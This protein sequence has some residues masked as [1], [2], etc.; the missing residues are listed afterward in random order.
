M[1]NSVSSMHTKK[2]TISAFFSGVGGIELGFEQTGEFRVVYANEF[3]KNAQI[4][5]VENYPNIHLDKRDIHDVLESEVPDSDVI[6]GGFPCQAFSI[7]G[8]RKGFEDERGD[9]F[10]ELLRIIKSKQPEV[11]F[12]ENVKNMVTHDHGNT[13]KI[14]REAL[15]M[16]GYFIKWKVLN[17]KEYGNIPQNR[18]RIYVVGFRNKNSFEKFDFPQ[19]IPLTKTLKDVINF[20]DIQDDKFYYKDGRQPFYDKLADQIT[21]ENTIYQWRRQYVRENKSGVVPTLTANMGTGGHNVPLIKAK[22]GIRKLT[23]RETFNVQGYPKNFK[24]PDISNAQLYKQAGN[25]VVVPVIKRIATNIANALN[26]D[27]EPVRAPLKEGKYYIMHTK[28]DGRFSGESSLVKV[29][30]TIEELESFA[31]ERKI[32]FMSNKEYLKN[33]QKNKMLDFYSFE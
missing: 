27:S 33:V 10:F 15:N 24:L 4:T 22:S 2:F 23:P 16:N 11:I 29:V 14:I 9:L 1:T 8:Y 30:S 21:D 12:I 13:F 18:E 25:S 3:D 6:V 19:K 32:D 7:A 17:G 20:N 26:I 5:Y 31:K 28:M